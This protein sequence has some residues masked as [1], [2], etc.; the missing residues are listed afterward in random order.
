MATLVIIKSKSKKQPLASTLAEDLDYT[1]VTLPEDS[2]IRERP[3]TGTTHL[4]VYDDMRVPPIGRQ[5]MHRWK[6]LCGHTSC[7]VLEL[8]PMANHSQQIS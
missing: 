1:A 7:Y 8:K 2:W 6:S 4:M 5:P 3:R